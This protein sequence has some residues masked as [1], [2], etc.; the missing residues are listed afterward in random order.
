M[1][2]FVHVEKK[3]RNIQSHSYNRHFS[4]AD[5]LAVEKVECKNAKKKIYYIKTTS[6]EKRMR[7]VKIMTTA[8]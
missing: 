2:V 1:F 7:A 3:K 6:R 5:I 4:N 8:K